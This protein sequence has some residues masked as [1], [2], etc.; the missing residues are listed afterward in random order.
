MSR[1]DGYRFVR[2]YWV[3]DG[4]SRWAL[5]EKIDGRMVRVG[6]AYSEAEY[7]AFLLR[8]KNEF[9]AYHN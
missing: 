7:K 6:T 5:W 3:L 2:Q 9:H 1:P 4:E 8:E